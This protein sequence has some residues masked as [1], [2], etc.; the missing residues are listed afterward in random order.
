MAK[1]RKSSPA[2]D[3]NAPAGVAAQAKETP[4][5]A[6]PVV[7]EKVPLPVEEQDPGDMEGPENILTDA[8]AMSDEE[9]AS[10][11]SRDKAKVPPQAAVEVVE[12]IIPAEEVLRVMQDQGDFPTKHYDVTSGEFEVDIEVRPNPEGSPERCRP[13]LVLYDKQ[14]TRVAEIDLPDFRTLA[15][16]LADFQMVLNQ[17]LAESARQSKIK[18]MR[19]A[20]GDRNPT[21]DIRPYRFTEQ[22][23]SGLVAEYHKLR[24]RIAEDGRDDWIER[25]EA[26][27]AELPEELL[28]MGFPGI[29]DPSSLSE[30]ER[31]AITADRPMEDL[32][33]IVR[34]M[35]TQIKIEKDF[36]KEETVG[37]VQR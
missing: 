22:G 27:F 6:A 37:V 1:R 5:K 20:L 24:G 3:P 15:L 13:C 19:K 9:V 12:A 26:A 31:R 21:E 8:Q 14:K 33:P 17:K 28:S 29:D 18:G 11:E 2:G 10:I 7:E 23:D 16:E 25:H 36:A 34:Q 4:T 32:K 30:A 35:E